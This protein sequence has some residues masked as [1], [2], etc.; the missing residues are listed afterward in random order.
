MDRVLQLGKKLF[1]FAMWTDPEPNHRPSAQH[2]K[3]API[4]IDANRVNWELIVNLLE[5]QRRMS[6][7]LSPESVS[8]LRF[9]MNRGWCSKKEFSELL[10]GLGLHRA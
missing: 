7:I 10:R 4:Q 8:S 5:T 6:G 2:A 9:R 3:R 1:I